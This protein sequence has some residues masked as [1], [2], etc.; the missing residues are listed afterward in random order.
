[1][2]TRT[3]R[4]IRRPSELRPSRKSA[5][6]ELSSLY[7]LWSRLCSRY[8][9]W[10]RRSRQGPCPVAESWVEC[11][12]AFHADV[13]PGPSNHSI[14]PVDPDLPLGPS[15]FRWVPRATGIKGNTP[16][17]ISHDGRSLTIRGWA[18]HLGIPEP[19]LRYRLRVGL[20]PEQALVST[21]LRKVA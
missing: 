8:L 2:T 10:V 21:D 4:R 13:A 16:A 12:D 7:R 14:K 6:P 20:P 1:M 15:N 11:F 9:A 18:E 3:I 17:L 5:D 19:T